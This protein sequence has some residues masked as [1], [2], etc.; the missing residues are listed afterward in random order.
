MDIVV[1]V[2]AS[3]SGAY[4][5]GVNRPLPAHGRPVRHSP[6]FAIFYWTRHVFFFYFRLD[7][8]WF[9]FFG[10]HLSYRL[11]CLRR[12]P[13]FSPSPPLAQCHIVAGI[14]RVFCVS[15]LASRFIYLFLCLRLSP[16]TPSMSG[17]IAY[18]CL[19]RD[20]EIV[21]GN[22]VV[23][24]TMSIG[25]IMQSISGVHVGHYCAR[26]RLRLQEG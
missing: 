13:T 20:G 25:C 10:A 8:S 17:D 6:L 7:D 14:V 15:Y 26:I 9:S 16:P 21:G 5:L 23:E 24:S 2:D 18:Q 12:R 11:S 19:T 3:G 22:E 4:W 1:S